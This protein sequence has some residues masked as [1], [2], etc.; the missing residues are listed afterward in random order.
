MASL[1]LSARLQFQRMGLDARLKQAALENPGVSL[2]SMGF[3]HAKAGQG[4]MGINTYPGVCMHCGAESSGVWRSVPFMDETNMA[5]RHRH[6]GPLGM[7]VSMRAGA[8][9]RSPADLLQPVRTLLPAQAGPSP[10]RGTLPPGCH[11]GRQQCSECKAPGHG[12]RG[13]G[14]SSRG[15]QRRGPWQRSRDPQQSRPGLRR[16]GG[17]RGGRGR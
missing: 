9:W 5:R 12:S 6:D 13:S 11:P 17:G 1:V 4:S 14:R 3:Y 15:C 16:P 2:D 7:R 10:R 8:P